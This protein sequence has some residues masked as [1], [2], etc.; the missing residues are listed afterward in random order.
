MFSS[1]LPGRGLH[2][3][4]P[5]G[6]S[7]PDVVI[8]QCKTRGTRRGGLVVAALGPSVVQ[9]ILRWLR[10]HKEKAND[11]DNPHTCGNLHWARNQRLPA[12]RVL[13]RSNEMI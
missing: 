4:R 7:R 6:P 5:V 10:E 11:V 1:E 8:P 3:P 13:I 12:R 2:S 9:P